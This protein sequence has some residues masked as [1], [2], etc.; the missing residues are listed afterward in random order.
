MSD[1]PYRPEDFDFDYDRYCAANASRYW[2]T[3]WRPWDPPEGPPDWILVSRALC[4]YLPDEPRELIG[5]LEGLRQRYEIQ[6]SFRAEGLYRK[7]P[8]DQKA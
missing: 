6:A 3:L 5:T 1:K 4:C 8:R 7:S 2:P